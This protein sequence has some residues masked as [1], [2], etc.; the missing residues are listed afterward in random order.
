MALVQRFLE[1]EGLHA[2]AECLSHELAYRRITPTSIDAMSKVRQGG[3]E[4]ALFRRLRWSKEKFEHLSSFC[5]F[6]PSSI[7]TSRYASRDSPPDHR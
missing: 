3:G 6:R 1:E 5:V 2:S 4:G 7:A